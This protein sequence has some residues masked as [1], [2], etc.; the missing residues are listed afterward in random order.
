MMDSIKDYLPPKRFSTLAYVCVILHLMCGAILIAITMDSKS[1]DMEK[2][3]CA[4][5][6][7]FV[8]H[9]TYVEKT[10][11]SN[12][13]D[14]YNSHIRLFAFVMLSF[15]SVAVVSVIYSLL[16]ANRIDET[17][18]YL[19][20]RDET[21]TDAKKDITEPGRK[22][23]CVFYCYFIHLVARFILGVLFTILQYY[24]F[25]TNGFDSEF[26]CD[27]SALTQP[28]PT[29]TT[30]TMNTSALLSNVTCTN[31]AA[32]DKQF[33]ATFVTVCNVIAAV[34]ALTEVIY[35]TLHGFTCFNTQF[36]FLWSCD[37][38]FIT[39]Y[40][41]GK[42]YIPFQ[43]DEF[44]GVDNPATN[45]VE[46]YKKNVLKASLTLLDINYGVNKSLDEIFI[47]VVIQTKQAPLKFSK[48]MTR[49]EINDVY[50]KVPGNSIHLKQ[51]KDTFYPN[52]DT[53]G[54]PPQT[55]LALGRPGI[56][57]TVLTR[58]IMHDWARGIDRFYHGK[59]VFY[60]KFRWFHFEQLQTVTLRK[61][62]QVGSKLSK[63]EF[64]SVFAEI[65]A[66]PQN[67]IFIFDGLDEFGGNLEKFQ[68]FLDQSELS[69]DDP[70]CPMSANV[71]FIKILSGQILSDATVL[72]T[73]RPTANDVLS[74]LYFDRK[75]EIIG[76]TEQKIENYVEKFCANHKKSE[77]KPKIWNHIKSSELKNLCYIPVNCFI[78]CVTLINWIGDEGND[79]ALPTTLTE[80]Y[81]AA[82]V[83]FHK[84]H[85]RNETKEH[86]KVISDLEQLGFNGIENDQLIFDGEFVNEQMKESGLLHCLP[87][88]IFQIQPQICFIHLTVQE[89]LAAKHIV[90]T[91]E[92]EDI[93]EFIS[94]HVKDSKWHLVLQFLAGLLGKKMEMSDRYRSC[95]LAFGEHLCSEIEGEDI[96][97]DGKPCEVMLMKCVRETKSENIAR[98]IAV[99]SPLKRVTKIEKYTSGLSPSDWAAIVFV[100]KH[101]NFLTD[102]TLGNIMNIGCLLEIAKLFHHRCIESLEVFHLLSIPSVQV[103]AELEHLFS[104]VTTSQCRIIH[105][106][107]K[108]ARLKFSYCSITDA[109]VSNLAEFFKSGREICLKELHLNG[110]PIT[111]RGISE[112]CKV[113]GDEGFNQLSVLNLDH[114]T[115]GDDGM[116]ILCNTLREK[117]HGLKELHVHRCSLTAK[118]TVWLGQLLSDEH[119]KITHLVLRSNEKLGDEGVR[120][121]CNGFGQG[122]CKL[123]VLDIS[124]CSL[125]DEFMRDLS[126]VFGDKLCG[127]SDLSLSRNKSINDKGVGMLFNALR[128]KQCSL[129]NLDLS[130]CSLTKECMASLCEALGDEHC[131]LTKLILAVNDIG[132]EGVEM[133]CC[134]LVKEQCKLTSLNLL[135]CSLTDKCIPSLC[136]TV[137]NVRCRVTEL[138]LIVPESGYDFQNEF[139]SEGVKLLDEVKAVHSS[140]RCIIELAELGRF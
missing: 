30:A 119:C 130:R 94:S 131:R 79:N 107:C 115:I 83:Y 34:I 31:S 2:F 82:L 105:E 69:P 132:D 44:T 58:K 61:F 100:C 87:V 6:T 106:H 48:D 113:L 21:Q 38:Q 86:K 64:E 138:F 33:W 91:K 27:Y 84:N 1:D 133:L 140:V 112:L 66:N 43:N 104:A 53:N 36:P 22:T 8:T 137:G 109:C 122:Q 54:N 136:K 99:T 103:A 49:H 20:K 139:T 73:S 46:I 63:N 52:K 124:D 14:V 13:N 68:S 7:T 45:S 18:K 71:L 19:T 67:A 134:A 126:K 24:V 60:F 55:I 95:V 56:G 37:S 3:S 118:C 125:T 108:L 10:C 85:D 72:V 98:E 59:I 92:P 4:V 96:V 120:E 93:K 62:L 80:L 11:F 23:C 116:R 15:G 40:F 42:Q 76:F 101:L 89:F 65:W 41:L 114:N 77:L 117:Q 110:S 17:E 74:K 75:V 88:P 32:K 121:L 97:C 35:L 9:K 81:Q 135:N 127:L 28:D 29:I 50:T 78:V 128:V 129:A 111:S 57:K 12:Y 16:V 5:N 39:E 70:T 51:V 26:T 90:E 25:Y 123:D 102:L 47:D